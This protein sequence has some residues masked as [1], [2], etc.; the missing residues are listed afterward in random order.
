MAYSKINI[1]QILESYSAHKKY[2]NSID[3]AK[4]YFGLEIDERINDDIALRLRMVANIDLIVDYLPP[5]DEHTLLVLHYLKNI[6]VEKCAECL[7]ISTRTCY[8]LLDKAL[9][10]LTHKLSG[11]NNFVV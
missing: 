2:I 11:V 8:R 10:L 6:P 9:V 3:Y 1:K 4:T 7:N 5:S